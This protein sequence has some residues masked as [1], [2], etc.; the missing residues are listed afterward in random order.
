MFKWT[1]LVVAVVFLSAVDTVA[2]GLWA[3]EIRNSVLMG[4]RCDRISKP[5][6]EQFFVSLNEL[7]VRLSEPASYGAHN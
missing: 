1:C 3:Y 7:N 6:S 2:Q 5:D 4:L